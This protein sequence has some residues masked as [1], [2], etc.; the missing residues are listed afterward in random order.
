MNELRLRVDDRPWASLGRHDYFRNRER[1][2]SL[3]AGWNRLQVKLDNPADGMAG[4]SWGSW[5]FALRAIDD[6]GCE[7]ALR[8]EPARRPILDVRA[9]REPPVRGSA[10]GDGRHI[11]AAQPADG[12]RGGSPGWARPLGAR[13]RSRPGGP[14]GAARSR[15]PDSSRGTTNRHSPTRR[16]ARPRR[17]RAWRPCGGSPPR[18]DRAASGWAPSGSVCPEP[19]RRTAGSARPT[20]RCLRPPA[21]PAARDCRE[22]ACRSDLRAPRWPHP[23]RRSRCRPACPARTPRCRSACPGA[24]RRR[25]PSRRAAAA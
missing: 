1:R 19:P 15:A 16:D 2:L 6:H 7:L 18:S 4:Q 23:G 25:R 22:S 9:V 12:H 5:V 10:G 21:G 17:R 3:R 13:L 24:R 8:P 20:S 11:P 14:V